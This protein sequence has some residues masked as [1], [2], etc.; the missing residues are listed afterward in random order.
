MALE[1]SNV[2]T[3]TVTALIYGTIFFGAIIFLPP[4]AIS[5]MFALIFY[6]VALELYKLF[7]NKNYFWLIL[8]IYPLFSFLI[9]IYLAHVNKALLIL[10]FLSVFIF[11]TGAY[12]FGSAFGKHKLCP[13]ISPNKSWEGF[14]GGLLTLIIFLRFISQYPF[15]QL[16]LVSLIISVLAVLGD[17]FES[18]LKRMSGVKDSGKLL[19]GHGGYLDRFDSAIFAAPFFLLIQIFFKGT[20]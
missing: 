12:F 17:F 20:L 14:F 2:L 16:I 9:M 8:P 18:Y 15:G 19:P 10:L 1:L 6:L 7:S 13:A 11:D 5:C 3:R 4:F